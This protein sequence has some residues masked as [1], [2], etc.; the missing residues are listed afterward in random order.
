VTIQIKNLRERLAD[1]S[2]ETRRRTVLEIAQA[3]STD[4]VVDLLVLALGDDDWRVRKEAVRIASKLA[5][6]ENVTDRLIDAM[7]QEENV[8]LRNAVSEALSTSDKEAIGC[9][10]KRTPHLVASGRKIAFEVLGATNDPRAID[11]L[12]DGL[13]DPD[14]NVST[15]AAEW[16]GEV[17]GDRAIDALIKCLTSSDTLLVLAT[18]QSLNRIGAVIPWGILETLS[19][20]PIYCTELLISLG[21]SHSLQAAPLIKR[22]LSKNTAAATAMDLLYHSSDRAAQSVLS[23]LKEVN[24]EEIAFLDKLAH[25][26]TPGEQLAATACLIWSHSRNVIPLVVQLA[27]NESLYVFLLDELAKWGS[28]ALHMLEEMM[29]NVAG[30]EL[31]SVIGLLARLMD[32]DA[33]LAKIDLFAS[34]LDFDDLIVA[35]AA[36]SAVSRF[37]DGRV[38]PKLVGLLESDDERLNRVAGY[39]LVEI[40]Q[41]HPEVV[42]QNLQTVEIEGRSGMQLCRIMEVV[43]KPEDAHQLTSALSSSDP[44]L[45]AAAIGAL[46]TISKDHAVETIA[47][48]MTDEDMTVRINAA[49]ALGR[50][51]PAASETIVSALY[52]AEGPLK[53]AL[54]RALG[55]VGHGEAAQILKKMCQESAEI[56]MAALEAM[57]SLRLDGTEIQ[58]EILRHP[59]SEVVKQALAVFGST[60]YPAQLAKLLSNSEWDVR[61]A[62]VERLASVQN[63]KTVESILSKHLKNETNDLVREAIELIVPNSREGD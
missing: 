16:L 34:Y 37:G 33:G 56:A 8:G 4:E 15:C 59:D 62:A 61:L 29:P 11:I 7:V 13:S 14:F 5:S 19:T 54:I 52:S 36:A 48:A 18:L 32:N 63:D 21:R 40:A 10:I 43:G 31:A 3:P 20:N 39:A 28:P 1:P 2:P 44:Q 42:H 38:V 25:E 24:E 30:K 9:L 60:V 58:E 17:G 41:R 50:I 46:A 55:Q 22:S 51:G 47:L 6:E 45:R 49:A 57:R 27:P 26:G 12:I 53:A 23:T 35:T